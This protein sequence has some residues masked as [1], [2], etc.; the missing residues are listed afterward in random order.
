MSSALALSRATGQPLRVYWFRTRTLNCP[1]GRLFEPIKGVEVADVAT[2]HLRAPFSRGARQLK[3][4]DKRMPCD[5][6]LSGD[7]IKELTEQGIDVAAAAARAKRCGIDTYGR[8]YGMAPYYQDFVPKSEL[9]AE[10]AKTLTATRSE[11]TGRIVGVHIR[12]GDNEASIQVSPTEAFIERMQREM[13]RDPEVRFFLATDDRATERV[14]ADRFPGRVSTR[15]K[16]LSRTQAAGVRDALVDLLVL[17]KCPLI[18]GSYWSSFSQT[19]AELGG[20]KLEIV[21]TPR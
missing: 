3:A 6:F 14:V 11:G 10:A 13:D 18:L 15:G 9:A 16:E 4:A 2:G 7:K 5:L 21:R 12:R 1:Y 17:S 20:G 19:A 8:F